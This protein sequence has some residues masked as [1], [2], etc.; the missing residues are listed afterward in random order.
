[1]EAGI[2]ASDVLPA[3]EQV[4]PEKRSDVTVSSGDEDFHNL[5]L[6]FRFA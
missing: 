5:E 3:I 2:D 4:R 1:M 6:Q